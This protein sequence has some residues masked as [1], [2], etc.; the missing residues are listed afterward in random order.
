MTWENKKRSRSR[1]NG[2]KM[3]IKANKENH[4]ADWASNTEWRNESGVV[5]G[6]GT[7][8]YSFPVINLCLE[9]R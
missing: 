8:I 3:E 5:G 6:G 2:K 4:K 7:E 1:R 9:G